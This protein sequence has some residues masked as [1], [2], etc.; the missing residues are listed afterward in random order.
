MVFCVVWLSLGGAVQWRP[1]PP[2]FPSRPSGLFGSPRADL[3]V[4]GIN[5][6]SLPTPFYPVLVSISVFMALSTVFHSINSPDNSP[7]SYSLRT[8]K[9]KSHPVRTQSWNVL[10]LK[11]GVGQYIAIHATLTASDFFLTYFYP[12]GPFTCIFSKTS[13]D[14]F[15]VG[16]G[17]HLVPV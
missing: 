8:Q 14:F 13:P 16:C 11:T 1:C 9:L 6:P 15:C 3:R 10:L 12:S 4:V 5:Q 2:S 7:L 17:S